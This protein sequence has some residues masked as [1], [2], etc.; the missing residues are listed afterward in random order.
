ASTTGIDVRGD[1]ELLGHQCREVLLAAHARAGALGRDP[2]PGD[3]G[4]PEGD[5]ALTTGSLVPDRLVRRS[6]SG[7]GRRDQRGGD[8]GEDDEGGPRAGSTHFGR[9]IPQ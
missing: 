6:C 2:G 9:L 7:D 1:V 3:E 8:Q 5:V 4:V